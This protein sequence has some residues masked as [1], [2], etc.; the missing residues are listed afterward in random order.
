[1]SDEKVENSPPILGKTITDQHRASNPFNSAW[2][3][4]NAGSGKTYVLTQR[5]VRLLLNDI[6]PS[7]I[8]CLTFTN[9]AAAQMS[10]RVFDLLSEWTSLDDKALTHALLNTGE[11]NIS[12]AKLLRSRLLFTR[13]LESP[14]GLK[15]QT[16]HGFCEA[17]LHQFTL[18]ANTSG[19][20]EVMADF[21]QSTLLE[22]ARRSVMAEAGKQPHLAKALA[23]AMSFASDGTIGNSLNEVIK[24]RQEFIQWLN[25]HEANV[26]T[27]IIALGKHIDVDTEIDQETLAEY[28]LQNL[29]IQDGRLV[30]IGKSAN[31]LKEVECKRIAHIIDRYQLAKTQ[32]E[33]FKLRRQLYQTSKGEFK[34]KIPGAVSLFKQIPDLRE[35]FENEKDCMIAADDHCKNWKMLNASRGLFIIANEVVQSYAGAKRARGLL[36][37]DDLINR[38]ADLLA[39]SDVRQ[40][41]QY[42]LDQG[43]DHVLVDEAQDTSPTQWKIIDA[44]IDEFFVGQDELKPGKTIFA[45]GDPK[46]SIFSFQ[47]AEPEMFSLQRNRLRKRASNANL[48]FEEVKLPISFRS[49]RDVLGA[50]DKIFANLQFADGLQD[51]NDPVIHEPVRQSDPGEVT[52]WPNIVAE[53][54]PVQKDWRAPL[55]QPSD[56]HPAIQLA[57]Y[58]ADQIKTWIEKGEVIHG[59][60]RKVTPGD[61]LILVKTRGHFADAITR[62]LK[63]ANLKVAGADRLKLANHIA[64]EDLLSLAKWALFPEDDLALA[65]VLKSPLFAI[66]EEQLFTLG[67]ERSGKTLWQSLCQHAKKPDETQ[68]ALITSELAKLKQISG[69]AAPFEFFNFILSSNSGRLRFKSRLGDEVDDVL[70]AFLLEALNHTNNGGSG[71]Q[72]FIHTLQITEPEIKREFDQKNDEI[73]IMTVHAAKGLEA[74]IVILVDPGTKSFNTSFRPTVMNI[75]MGTFSPAFIWQPTLADGSNLT[76]T[77]LEEIRKKAEQ[78]Y[79]RL[80]YVGM[81]RAE[82]RLLICGYRTFNAKSNHTWMNMALESLQ[83]TC[84]QI[85]TP[86]GEQGWQWISDHQSRIAR[87]YEHSQTSEPKTPT[88]LPNWYGT[89]LPLE[90]PSLPPILPSNATLNIKAAPR[91]QDKTVNNFDRYALEKGNAVHYLLEHLPEINTEKQSD[92]A[93]SYLNRIYPHW[94][95]ETKNTLITQ[96]FSIL[97]NPQFSTLFTSTGMA[98]ISLTGTLDPGG[99][100]RRVSGQ[101]D[102]LAVFEDYVLIADYKSDRQIPTESNKVADQYLV[103]LAIYRQLVAQI[104]PDK[105]IKCTLLWT[106]GPQMMEIETELLVKSLNNWLIETK[107]H[108]RMNENTAT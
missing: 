23:L 17:L 24:K 79:R 66:N 71:L 18:E 77:I 73:R 101:I 84:T 81:T 15:I 107:T 2:V 70:D 92:W 72:E 68:F 34:K 52:I 50:V 46:Q 38:S 105:K 47:G 28:L 64:V 65:E 55:D 25:D 97:Q 48:K 108:S 35:E 9:A 103:Q 98:E 16:L 59:Q 26:S 42:K 76:K 75:D 82:D 8:L 58:V 29:P 7:K 63:Q 54:T 21:E 32:T 69:V 1:M 39:R 49:T 19:H 85:S 33:R 83:D 57:G 31:H 22:E 106:T 10:N 104:Y 86:W 74:P 27:A 89:K 102:R 6:A 44:I 100:N 62:E 87:P 91:Q 43:I 4:A 40:W 53:R 3:S 20:F 93:N 94:N 78:E 45:V 13:A 5:V 14:G 56:K 11:T 90:K 61:I 80:L 88:T 30:E 99:L 41:V 51:I 96:T 12:P 67:I 95:E 37:F 36:D 60:G